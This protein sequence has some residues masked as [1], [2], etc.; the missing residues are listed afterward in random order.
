MIPTRLE[1]FDLLLTNVTIGGFRNINTTFI[2]AVIHQL[3]FSSFMCIFAGRQ[4]IHTSKVSFP[5]FPGSALWLPAPTNP[6]SAAFSVSLPCQCLNASD[7]HLQPV[8]YWNSGWCF[9]LCWDLRAAAARLSPSSGEDG[10]LQ[11]CIPL[12]QKHEEEE[13]EKSQ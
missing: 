2:S 3:I 8:A 12:L 1:S 9:W 5:D 4:L 13:V 7:C 11:G 10:A 6:K